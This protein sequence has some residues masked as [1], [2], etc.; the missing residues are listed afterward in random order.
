MKESHYSVQDKP[1]DILNCGLKFHV[2][3]LFLLKC[4]SIYVFLKLGCLGH[5]F[6]CIFLA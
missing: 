4:Y 6:N 5:I 1:Q 2:K 3:R